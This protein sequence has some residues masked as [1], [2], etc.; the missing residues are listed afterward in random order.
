MNNNN[1]LY[2]MKWRK[3]SQFNGRSLKKCFRNNKKVGRYRYFIRLQS[4]LKHQIGIY[5]VQMFNW[6]CL[7]RNL[8]GNVEM[9]IFF[10]NVSKVIQ[11][12]NVMGF[13]FSCLTQC[14][15]HFT[16]TH[17][18][19]FPGCCSDFGEQSQYLASRQIKVHGQSLIVSI[20]YL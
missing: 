1:C 8:I 9:G 13:F 16:S 6:K 19:V 17:T 20:A 18:I 5:I 4:Y 11:F 3:R 12:A 2:C 10:A 14:E 7:N 15:S